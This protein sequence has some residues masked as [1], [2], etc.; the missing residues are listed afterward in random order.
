MYLAEPIKN[1]IIDT[2]ACQKKQNTQVHSITVEKE[3][4][5]I[6]I[7]IAKPNIEQKPSLNEQIKK[8]KKYIWIAGVFVVGGIVISTIKK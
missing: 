4:Q 7:N 5:S 2:C 1:G 8:Y 3:P 6:I